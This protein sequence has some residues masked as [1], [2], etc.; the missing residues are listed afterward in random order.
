MYKHTVTLNGLEARVT[1]DYGVNTVAAY[2]ITF[3]ESGDTVTETESRQFSG[4]CDQEIIYTLA[5][6]MLATRRRIDWEDVYNAIDL[7]CNCED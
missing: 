1:L 5:G 6:E 3:D 2:G 7:E 4:F